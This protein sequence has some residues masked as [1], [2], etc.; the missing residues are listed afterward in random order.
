MAPTD[1]TLRVRF[2]DATEWLGELRL[3]RGQTV[4]PRYVRIASS[5]SPIPHAHDAHRV[6]LHASAIVEGMPVVLE[7]Y[8]GELRGAPS[9]Y[10]PVHRALKDLRESVVKVCRHELNLEIRVGG[11]LED[12]LTTAGVL[13]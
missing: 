9:N 11:I 2:T 13:G 1:G 8:V 5:I 6:T 4:A 3:D 7:H 12:T 10:G